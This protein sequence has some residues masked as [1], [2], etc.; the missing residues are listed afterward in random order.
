MWL[1]ALYVPGMEK[2]NEYWIPPQWCVPIHSPAAR[3]PSK[4]LFSLAGRLASQ[5]TVPVG[6]PCPSC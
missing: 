4:A 2:V 3:V 1:I 6:L 5:L